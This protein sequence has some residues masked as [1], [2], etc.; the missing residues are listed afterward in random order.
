MEVLPRRRRGSESKTSVARE[1]PD[2]SVEYVL[3]I[4]LFLL[5]RHDGTTVLFHFCGCLRLTRLPLCGRA[6]SVACVGLYEIQKRFCTRKYIR[7]GCG[8]DR[9]HE[10]L[11]TKRRFRANRPPNYAVPAKIFA[12]VVS[13]VYTNRSPTSSNVLNVLHSLRCAQSLSFGSGRQPE[14]MIARQL[15]NAQGKKKSSSKSTVRICSVLPCRPCYLFGHCLAVS[16]D[17]RPASALFG[18][19][20][21]VLLPPLLDPERLCIDM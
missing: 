4:R 16:L 21:L 18:L 5:R 14:P 19:R 11:K 9:H 1:T 10:C 12:F 7:A 8:D 3:G 2:N 20:V 15:Q 17:T 13:F 6:P